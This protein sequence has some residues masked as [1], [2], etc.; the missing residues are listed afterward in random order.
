LVGANFLTSFEAQ[1][2][3]FNPDKWGD[4]PIF[5]YEKLNSEEKKQL[6]NIELGV[7]TLPQE[8]LDQHS[9]PEI[10]AEYIPIIEEEWE[11]IMN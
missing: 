5:S 8:V 11:K 9:L 2:E 4:L 6:D 7:A 1:L 10:P 3:K